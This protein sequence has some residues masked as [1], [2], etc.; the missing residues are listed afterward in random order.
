[1][2]KCLV[3]T[4]VDDLDGSSAADETVHFAINGQR[5]EIDLTAAHA[6]ELRSSLYIYVGAARRLPVFRLKVG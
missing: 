1:M 5:Y 2:A 4:L 3:T 6:A